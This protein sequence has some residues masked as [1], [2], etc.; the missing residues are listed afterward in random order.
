MKRAGGMFRWAACQLDILQNCLDLRMLHQSLKSL[1]TTLEETYARILAGIDF[2]HREYTTRILQFLTYS[3]RPVTIEESVD[4]VAV[5][6]SGETAFDFELR[7][8]EPLEIA[9][10]CSSLIT[11]VVK[12]NEDDEENKETLT[13][14]RLAHFSV[15]QYLKSDRIAV[16]FGLESPDTGFCLNE[17]TARAEITR[18]CLAYLSNFDEQTQAEVIRRDFPFSGYAMDYWMDHAKLGEMETSVLEAILKF[19]HARS[20]PYVAWVRHYDPRFSRLDTAPDHIASGTRH[21]TPTKPFSS[22]GYIESLDMSDFE[23]SIQLEMADPLYHASFGGLQRTVEALIEKGGDI[24]SQGGRYVNA[25]HAASFRGHVEVVQ[26][27]LEKGADINAIGGLYRNTVHNGTPG[28]VAA[29]YELVDMEGSCKSVLEVALSKG[30]TETV[31]L[32]LDKGAYINT[33]HGVFGNKNHNMS[34]QMGISYG[35]ITHSGHLGGNA[36]QAALSNGYKDTV[37]LLLDRGASLN[38]PSLFSYS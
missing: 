12:R 4:I 25:L 9:R 31:Q 28:T 18:I 7:M 34:I 32:L 3:G 8:P 21:L 14:I 10:V 26:L 36:L 11:L 22:A 1:P 27:L 38:G 33:I 23:V 15:Q 16:S 19:F 5:D 13:E 17:K 24:N 2:S 29:N 35:S 6:S 20:G 30:H 37:Q